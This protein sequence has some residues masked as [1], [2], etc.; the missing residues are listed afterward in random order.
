MTLRTDNY[1]V[2]IYR[3]FIPPWNKWFLSFHDDYCQTI[4]HCIKPSL[5]E[6]WVSKHTTLWFPFIKGLS[7]HDWNESHHFTMTTVKL[8]Y[9]KNFNF[10]KTE[11]EWYNF[12]VAV[13][14]GVIPPWM[15]WNPSF[16]DDYYLTIYHYKNFH[17]LKSEFA[18]HTTLW[19]PFIKGSSPYEWYEIHPFTMTT[20][21]IKWNPSFYNEYYQTQILSPMK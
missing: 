20:A 5:P 11:F 18:K 3:G 16:H 12:G 9:C 8:Y 17:Y 15:K 10:L 7:P 14:K 19:F 4:Y 21:W 2:T 13:Y 1:R 6:K